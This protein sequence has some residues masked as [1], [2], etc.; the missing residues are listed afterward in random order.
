MA[1]ICPSTIESIDASMAMVTVRRSPI[2]PRAQRAASGDPRPDRRAHLRW[3]RPR[4]LLAGRV[5]SPELIAAERRRY[6]AIETIRSAL[7]AHAQ[8]QVVPIPIDC[9]DGFTEAFY[10][11]PSGF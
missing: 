4:P 3:R 9:V 11:T 6:P 10:A 8:V 7:G 5:I 1:E 2:R